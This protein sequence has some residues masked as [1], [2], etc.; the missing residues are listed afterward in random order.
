MAQ[1]LRFD[2]HTHLTGTGCCNSGCWVSPHFSKRYTFRLLKLL[3]GISNEQMQTTVDVDW[4]QMLSSLVQATEI[5]YAVALGFDGCYDEVDGAHLEHKSQ[6]IVPPEWVFAVCR[7]HKN[8][9]PGPSI[10]PHRRDAMSRLEYCVENGAVLIKW[11]P[12]SQGIDPTSNKLG[13]FYKLLAETQIPLLVHMGGERTFA[14]IRP[15]ANDVNALIPALEAGCTVICAHSATRILAAN[16]PDQLPRL[17][18][19]LAQYPRL[20]LDNSGLCNP[21]RFPHVPR[22]AKDEQFTSRTLYGSDWPVPS[23][24]LYYTKQLGV[25]AV[26]NLERQKNLISRDVATKRAL[27][28]PD[29]TLTQASGV[30]ANLPR[31][32]KA[33]T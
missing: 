6:M 9:L 24:A 32:V 10:N 3:Y 23:N 1:Q 29:R 17:R 20:W 12:A 19:L 27:G 30:L 21:G 22:L 13:D 31:W 33:H 14:T 11:L 4:A 8:L 15:E 5:D 26:W 2:V 25:K 16:E 18:E 7:R 28:Y